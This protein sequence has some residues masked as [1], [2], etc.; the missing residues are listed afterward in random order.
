MQ[1]GVDDV[2]RNLARRLI[3]RVERG[4]IRPESVP[5]ADEHPA[6]ALL[7]RHGCR[8][9]RR[10]GRARGVPDRRAVLEQGGLQRVHVVVA[11]AGHDPRALGVEHRAAVAQVAG[12]RDVGDAA[13]GDPE[14][15]EPILLDV[16]VREQLAPLPADPCVRDDV[17]ARR[18]AQRWHVGHQYSLRACISSSRISVPH[19]RHGRPARW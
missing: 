10:L 3:E 15:D 2:G 9:A 17:D 5:H 4:Q 19:T 1:I 14:I 16:G 18:H 11:Q 6:T 12:G 8:D 7:D 13:A